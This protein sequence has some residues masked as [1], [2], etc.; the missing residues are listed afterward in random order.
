MGATLSASGGSNG[1]EDEEETETIQYSE[2][3]FST[4]LAH[5]KETNE[6][7]NVPQAG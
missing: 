2:Y 6:L 4:G 3:P 5:V 7:E 1:E